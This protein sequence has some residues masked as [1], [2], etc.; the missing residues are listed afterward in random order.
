MPL[1]GI[2]AVQ[3]AILFEVY[4][5]AHGST[6]RQVNHHML[7]PHE[8]FASLHKAER[9]EVLYPDDEAAARSKYCK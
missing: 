9:Q 3:H 5:D 7:L 2:M 6:T 1:T 4:E 8:I